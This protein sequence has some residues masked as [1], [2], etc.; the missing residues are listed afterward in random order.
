MLP[1]ELLHRNIKSEEACENLNVLNN[2]LLDTATFVYAKIKSCR[3]KSNLSNGDA[4]TLKNLTKQKDMIIKNA[5]KWNTVVILDK[6]SYIEKVKELLSDTC[7]FECLEIPPD[8]HL[9]IVINS[10]DNVGCRPGIFYGQAKVQKPVINNFHLLDQ[11][12]TLLTHNRKEKL[13]KSPQGR[14][15]P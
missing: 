5:A 2:K 8:K 15:N 9:N 12:L 1:F 3:L 10:H 14:E 13:S 4:N 11:N 6:E 7:K